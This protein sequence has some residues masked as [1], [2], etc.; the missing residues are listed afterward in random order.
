MRFAIVGNNRIEAQPKLQGLCPCCFKPVVA[1]CGEQKVWHWAH[2]GNT[3]CDN[4]W[5]KETE[6]HRAWK[7]NYPT[8]WQEKSLF[9]EK[10]GEK[11]IADVCTIRNLVIEFQHSYISQ[12]ERVSREQFYK[13]MVWV[14]DGTR[15]QRDYTRFC[16]GFSDFK[17]T[18]RKGFFLVDFPNEVFPKS[19]LGSKV[20][21]IF[22]FCG[23]STDETDKIKN[24]LWC[25]L[26]QKDITSAIIVGL[27]KECF[28][29]LTHNRE[30]LFIEESAEPKQRSV[31]KQLPGVRM[32]S[33][34]YFDN[35]KGIW[36][37]KRRF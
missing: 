20:P 19:W 37:K 18:K 29:Q 1:K 36:R 7:N 25:L 8:E 12:K 30:R 22:D 34:Y 5:E 15:L 27:K 32:K 4:W 14:V 35:C 13:N 16:K 33:Q 11:H 31:P 10:T 17:N 2:R 9:D 28:I 21:V 3:A 6:W 26:P 23:M 24:I